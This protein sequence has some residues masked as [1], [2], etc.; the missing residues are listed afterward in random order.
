MDLLGKNLNET[1]VPPE[2]PISHNLADLG[3]Q[4][5][6]RPE[7]FLELEND[8]V[9][10]DGRRLRVIWK[11]TPLYDTEGEQ[12]GIQYLVQSGIPDV[13]EVVAQLFAADGAK[14]CGC[15]GDAASGG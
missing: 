5:L 10:Y 15:V 9:C 14:H 2:V 3:E 11:N 1:I 8:N 7:Q 4:L 6:A 13:C 12:V